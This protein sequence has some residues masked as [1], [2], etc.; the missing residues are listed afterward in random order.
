[1]FR[2][3]LLCLVSFHV[4]E[5][6]YIDDH[7]AATLYRREVTIPFFD[8]V[9]GENELSTLRLKGFGVTRKR[10]NLLAAKTGR[11]LLF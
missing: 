10:K 7:P 4:E 6:A 9:L 5:L 8:P 1:M 3:L 11:F 2:Y